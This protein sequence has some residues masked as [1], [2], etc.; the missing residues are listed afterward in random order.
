MGKV[1]KG[2]KRFKEPSEYYR[3]M[4]ICGFFVVVFSVLEY[5][6]FIIPEGDML[7]IV[8]AGRRGNS[9]DKLARSIIRTLMMIFGNRTG[10]IIG[11][12]V[13]Y[14]AMVHSF[15]QE[16]VGYIRYK[17]KCKLYHEGVI[18]NVYD[19]YDNEPPWSLFR[20]IK[21]LFTKKEKRCT[22]RYPSVRKMKKAIKR[23][24]KT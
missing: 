16:V 11:M 18:K 9:E 2:R 8:D 23:N 4:I 13:C 20:L 14:L 15:Y 3:A 24:G 7:E 17:K 21:R 22:K 6:A 12:S 1:E 5:Y 19:I 10:F